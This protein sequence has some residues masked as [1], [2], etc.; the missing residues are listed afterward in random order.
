MLSSLSGSVE[1]CWRPL[2][3]VEGGWQVLRGVGGPVSV[4]TCF[5]LDMSIRLGLGQR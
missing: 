1:G 4:P 5:G 3:G 2:R